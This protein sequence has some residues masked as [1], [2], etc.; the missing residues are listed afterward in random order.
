MTQELENQL[1]VMFTELEEELPAADFTSRVM[2]DVRQRGRDLLWCS[3]ILGTLAFLWLA[4]PDFDIGLRLVA[5]LPPALFDFASESVPILTKSPLLYVY[6]VP[7]G[8]YVLLRLM[9]RFHIRPF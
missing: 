6:G 9:H 2:W 3:A 5:G 7:L 1:K 4:F 8:G